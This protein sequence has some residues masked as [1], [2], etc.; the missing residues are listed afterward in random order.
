MTTHPRR[1]ACSEARY[2][3]LARKAD[4]LEA[5]RVT[6]YGPIVARRFYEIARIHAV[7][8]HKPGHGAVTLLL[9]RDG[10]P[11]IPPQTFREPVSAI[12]ESREM[13]ADLM[14]SK[15]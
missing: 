15:T 2:R 11:V 8:H 13:V 12:L 10:Q 1:Q 6:Q 3:H 7:V 14:R 4:G 5:E 9:I